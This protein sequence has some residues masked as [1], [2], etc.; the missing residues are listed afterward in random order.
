MRDSIDDVIFEM[1]SFWKATEE[2]RCLNGKSYKGAYNLALAA[3]PVPAI[4]FALSISEPDALRI[5]GG[6]CVP[7][8]RHWLSLFRLVQA[9]QKNANCYLAD[10]LI[11]MIFHESIFR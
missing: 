6:Q 4:K 5:R 1:P 8:P 11:H 10:M 2:G 3:V 9:R 7:H